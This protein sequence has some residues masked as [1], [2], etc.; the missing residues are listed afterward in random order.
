MLYRLI[1]IAILSF[2]VQ[3]SVLGQTTAIPSDY[4]ENTPLANLLDATTVSK[5][6]S[7][8]AYILTYITEAENGDTLLKVRTSQFI[9]AKGVS[10]LIAKELFIDSL[11]ST[12]INAKWGDYFL[13]HSTLPE[14]NYL[15]YWRLFNNADSLLAA[16]D[17]RYI[18]TRCVQVNAFTDSVEGNL[19]KWSIV[20]ESM[21]SNTGGLKA[22]VAFFNLN[23]GKY[24]LLS[25]IVQPDS[26][27][28]SIFSPEELLIANY[29][30][31]KKGS[32]FFN[33]KVYYNG[34]L[35]GESEKATVPKSFD[36]NLLAD[37]K[38]AFNFL[39]PEN[40]LENEKKYWSGQ[41]QTLKPKKE[42][43]LKLSGTVGS[44]SGYSNIKFP[45]QIN[46]PVYSRLFANPTLTYLGIPVTAKVFLSTENNTQYPVNA[47]SV[48]LNVPLLKAN[49]MKKIKQGNEFDS[50][51]QEKMVADFKN[52]D[53]YLKTLETKK[54]DYENQ[55]KN[56]KP[57]ALSKKDV[58][59][60]LDSVE[61]TSLPT[62]DTLT[63][64]RTVNTKTDSLTE[65]SI[66]YQLLE[67]YNKTIYLYTKTKRKY[68][69]LKVFFE[70]NGQS[71]ATMLQDSFS[72]IG[73]S[74]PPLSTKERLLMG[75]KNFDIG[76]VYPL[77]SD[78]TLKG[79]PIKG[80]NS[81]FVFQKHFV[82]LAIGKTLRLNAP[83]YVN[84]S[85]LPKF[86]RK[87][88]AAKGGIGDSDSNHFFVSVV[89]FKD[90]DNYIQIDSI[91]ILS[92]KTNTL[93]SFGGKLI[94][95]KKIS[96]EGEIVSS[97]YRDS[98]SY[99]ATES[100][101]TIGTSNSFMVNKVVY[102]KAKYSFSKNSVVSI[103]HK[104]IGAGY[105]SLGTPFLRR[106]YRETE[107]KTENSLLNKKITVSAFFKYN[108]DN[109]SHQK[110]FQNTLSGYGFTL[111]TKFR[112]SPNVVI[113]HTPFE[114]NS[115]FKPT[116]YS[117]GIVLPNLVNRFHLTTANVFYICTVKNIAAV[118]NLSFLNN[119][120]QNSS[121]QTFSQQSY[122]SNVNLTLPKGNNIT[123]M[124]GIYKTLPRVDTLNI[125]FIEG[126]TNFYLFKTVNTT[127]GGSYH[128]NNPQ[129]FK[130]GVFFQVGHAVKRCMIT[131]RGLFNKLEGNWGVGASKE[132]NFFLGLA[133]SL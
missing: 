84:T 103:S 105:I 89:H 67:Q 107:A 61:T 129:M 121:G 16:I 18:S 8:P 11:K 21:A 17:R 59:K 124:G 44:E 77:F 53:D 10:K 15:L 132:V 127:I 76:L 102:T 128:Q 56:Y 55:L 37:G 26:L 97:D 126:L 25:P 74:A 40:P 39:T 85:P 119:V 133:Y 6:S 47:F 65:A 79:L 14:G 117:S 52:T 109:L 46:P 27:D 106:D 5:S 38:K 32:Y 93:Y 122:S 24:K 91:T 50:Q 22:V 116:Q 86:E 66:Y 112:K 34:M 51:L 95:T 99:L 115:E 114:M 123:I 75:V 42:V 28:V 3:C 118:F 71:P 120:I 101:K 130:Y 69:R 98:R 48:G 72:S 82:S 58:T 1:A 100:T 108:V 54:L 33:V 111:R 83:N 29:R 96:I 110:S 64:N 4:N 88:V 35:L 94:A 113:T 43:A 49:L 125:R 41:Y 20:N 57:S 78:F 2:A 81:S 73:K 68:D 9:L 104:I 60:V 87:V 45:T 63:L 31:D 90:P 30:T 80:V 13:K 62:I 23:K 36:L 70:N 19:F 7:Q 92:P 131:V 12:L